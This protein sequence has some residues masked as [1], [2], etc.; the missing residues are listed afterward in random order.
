MSE[1][2]TKTPGCTLPKGVRKKKGMYD[3][4][5]PGC[6]LSKGNDEEGSERRGG[7]A[8]ARGG[9]ERATESGREGDL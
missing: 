8:R 3:I 2:A 7:S 9:R 6:T 4:K 5:T 1:A